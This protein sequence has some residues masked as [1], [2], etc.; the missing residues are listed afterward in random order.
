MKY[1]SPSPV[2][3]TASAYAVIGAT[4]KHS[5]PS[6]KKIPIARVTTASRRARSAGVRSV[7][8][9][10]EII[11]TGHNRTESL[12]YVKNPYRELSAPRH[13]SVRLP[14]TG[15]LVTMPGWHVKNGCS[16]AA[17]N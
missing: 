3:P 7:A 5:D 12:E 11:E 4:T 15:D 1:V 6:A 17:M 14:G 2:P 9:G 13:A 8:T 16:P 10:L